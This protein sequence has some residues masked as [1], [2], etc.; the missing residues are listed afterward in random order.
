[1]DLKRIRSYKRWFIYHLA[2]QKF[3]V[4]TVLVGISIV[5]LSRV[6]I[7]V[8]LGYIIDDALI[9]RD[10]SNLI[11]L[12]SIALVIF[13]I[14]N[15]MDYLTM[16]SGHY[17]GFKTEQN[18]RQ[19][20]F[21]TMQFKPL[22]YHDKARTGD[23]QALATNDLRIINTMIA[24]GAFYLYPFFQILMAGILIITLDLRLALI[25]T[26][27]ILLYIYFVLD[28]RNKI[29]PYAAER[30]VKH[31]NLA[32]ALQD[33]LSGAAVVKAFTAEELERQKFGQ[34]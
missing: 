18:M 16:M 19:E 25:V 26:P 8:V 33:S 31:S 15:V 24:H 3:W 23:L 5:T 30:M 27:F 14:R 6:L 28:Y 29:A 1:M 2:R 12:L 20:F 32:V 7:P 21:D 10:T 4:M 9:A 17:L 34:A 22:R 11:F 13:L